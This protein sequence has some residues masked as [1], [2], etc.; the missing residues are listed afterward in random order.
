M[1]LGEGWLGVEGTREMRARALLTLVSTM[2]VV[3]VTS[4]CTRSP[5]Y[6]IPRPLTQE[7]TIKTHPH[8]VTCRV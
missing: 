5:A 3:A 8:A 7:S 4:C 6:E 2:K 1:G